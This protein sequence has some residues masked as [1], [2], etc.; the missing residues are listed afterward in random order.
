M[1]GEGPQNAAKSSNLSKKKMVSFCD[2]ILKRCCTEKYC[3]LCKKHGCAHTAHNTPD[4]RKYDSNET[5]KKNF[6]GTKPTGTSCGP[7]KPA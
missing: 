3:S 7:E 6:K 4:R 2:R 5:P 1:V